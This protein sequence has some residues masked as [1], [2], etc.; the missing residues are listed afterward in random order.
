MLAWRAEQ[1][2]GATLLTAAELDDAR[3]QMTR[4]PRQRR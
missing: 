2:G 3:N 4:F 1:I